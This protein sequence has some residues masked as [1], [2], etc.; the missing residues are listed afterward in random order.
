MIPKPGCV[1]GM[2]MRSGSRVWNKVSRMREFG[3]WKWNI[4]ALSEKLQKPLA[5]RPNSFPA[6]YIFGVLN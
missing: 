3:N 1:M 6:R 5:L 4:M 2:R